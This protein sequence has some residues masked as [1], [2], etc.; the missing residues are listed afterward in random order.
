MVAPLAGEPV[1]TEL[2]ALL[3]V[4]SPRAECSVVWLDGGYAAPRAAISASALLSQSYAVP[5]AAAKLAGPRIAAA[6]LACMRGESA[7]TAAVQSA[8]QRAISSL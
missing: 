5:V 8:I 6:A 3:A 7:G 1:E 2:G 4:C